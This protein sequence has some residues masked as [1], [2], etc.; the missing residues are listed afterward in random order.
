MRTY[1]GRFFLI[2]HSY[3]LRFGYFSVDSSQFSE[4]SFPLSLSLLKE[5]IKWREQFVFIPQN[6][7]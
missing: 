5:N 1:Y 6:T 7:S 2:G 3:Q 4:K